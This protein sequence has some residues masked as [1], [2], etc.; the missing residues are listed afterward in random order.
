MS[1]QAGDLITEEANK[2]RTEHWQ[3]YIKNVITIRDT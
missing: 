2:I 3:N 1:S